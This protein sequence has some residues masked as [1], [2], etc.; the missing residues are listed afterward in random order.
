MTDNDDTVDRWIAQYP[1]AEISADEF[2]EF[3]ATLLRAG[4]PG[5]ANFTVALHEKIE[6]VDGEY[7]FDAT[8]RYEFLGMDFLVL[9]E[10]KCHKNAIK[11][12]L[13]QVLHQKGQ[14]V[15]AHKCVLVSTAP[16]Q[17][18]AVAFA[19]THG[20]ALV[21]MTE[22]RFT[23]MAHAATGAPP[24][25]REEAAEYHGLPTFAGVYFGAAD[26]PDSTKMAIID[27]GNTEYVQELLLAVPAEAAPAP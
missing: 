22:G 25:T 14:S 23:Y 24:M 9:V 2:E 10:A 11:R 4:E 17:R 8:V 27:A 19:K 3:V 18:G 7:D 6:G 5:L 16:F 21:T 13:V 12:E 20:I 15:G 1:S 26:T